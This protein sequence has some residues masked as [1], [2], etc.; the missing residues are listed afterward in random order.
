MVKN[1]VGLAAAMV[2]CAASVASGADWGD[3]TLT[4]TIDGKAPAAKAIVANKDPEVCGKQKLVDEALVVGGN[5]GIA[6][7]FVYLR[8]D[9]GKVPVHPDYEKVAKNEIVMDNKGCRFEPH[10]AVL[11]TSQTLVLKNSDPI[12]HNVKGDVQS[13][14][15]FNPIIPDADLHLGSVGFGRHGEKWSW[16]MA[17]HFALGGRTVSGNLS[18]LADGTYDLFNQAFSVSIRRRF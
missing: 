8:P 13:N 5:G 12:G 3:L 9:S 17:Y 2:G 11:W 1:W 18:P 15:A 10:A 6:D 4:F 16:Y 7:V 14:P